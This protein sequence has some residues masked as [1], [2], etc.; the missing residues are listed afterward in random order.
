MPVHASTT[1]TASASTIV[2][3]TSTFLSTTT[4][5][6][7]STTTIFAPQATFYA[8]CDSNNR[9]SSLNGNAIVNASPD[10]DMDTSTY[11]ASAYDCCV[12]CLQL[13]SCSASLFNYN[14]LESNVCVL[15]DDGICDPTQTNLELY[16]NVNN[17]G[18][19]YVVSNSNCGQAVYYGL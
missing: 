1:I 5:T 4:S 11:T 19:N 8:A 7:T 2:T 18:E 13:A 9:V 14:D 17:Y 10:Y 15:S 12:L 3:S 16:T 6:L